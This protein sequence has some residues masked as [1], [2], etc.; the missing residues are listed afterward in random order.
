MA[1]EAACLGGGNCGDFTGDGALGML[2]GLAVGALEAAGAA[3]PEACGEGPI[4][5][6]GCSSG[7]PLAYINLLIKLS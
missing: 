3:A 1:T 4:F 5:A 7:V 2:P 6:G